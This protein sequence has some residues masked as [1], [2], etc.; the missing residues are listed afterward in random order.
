[1][2]RDIKQK[3]MCFDIKDRII[4]MLGGVT[5]HDHEHELRISYHEGRLNAFRT[6]KDDM[7]YNP[8]LD[9]KSYLDRQVLCSTENVKRF[10]KE[11]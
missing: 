9:V 11:D 7:D 1:M 2:V 3:D 10:R 8:N 4:K 5:Q 6:T